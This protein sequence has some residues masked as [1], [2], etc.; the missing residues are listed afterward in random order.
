MANTTL[1]HYRFPHQLEKKILHL[2]ARECM[3]GN[4]DHDRRYWQPMRDREPIL[5]A[6]A[7]AV[8]E[9][10]AKGCRITYT[11]F[12]TLTEHSYKCYDRN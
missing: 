6:P 8:A 9:F 7:E 12:T 3:L 2:E 10:H 5:L 11:K 4:A 1:R